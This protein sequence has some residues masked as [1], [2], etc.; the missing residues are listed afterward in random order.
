MFQE[1]TYQGMYIIGGILLFIILLSAGMRYVISEGKLFL[2]FFWL[3]PI[4]SADIAKIIAA[5]RSYNP[6]S[7]PAFSL[8]RL[9]I[10]FAR[11]RFWLI[12][13]VREKEFIKALKEINPH[14][15]VNV[16][17]KKGMWRILDWDI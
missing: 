4:G 3:I 8:K 2:K 14:I 6:L 17:C 1:K 16:P 15:Y 11:G 12:S 10:T 13:P 5:E 9:H 7:S